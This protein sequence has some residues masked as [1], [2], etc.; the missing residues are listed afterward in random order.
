MNR[1]VSLFCSCVI[2]MPVLLPAQNGARPAA[3]KIADL[4]NDV[5][6]SVDHAMRSMDLAGFRDFDF[7][8]MDFPG[9]EGVQGPL[10][11]D[12]KLPHGTWWRDADLIKRIGLSSDQQKRIEDLFLQNKIQLI[13]LHASL[14]EE[15]LLLQP[16]LDGNPPDQ[17]KALTQI[18]KIADTRAD[19]EKANA[20]M[21][22]GI[23]GVLTG[24]QWTRLQAERAERR[25]RSMR[26]M[27]E[28]VKRLQGGKEPG[29]SRGRHAPP[30]PATPPQ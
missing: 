17:T 15:E 20:R 8:G 12:L 24:D 13:H 9:F 25:E 18:S 23:R 27:R 6:A 16:V 14:Q 19:L 29:I 4:S 3:P 10:F 11:A 21:L 1:I 22:L 28:M 2:A 5:Q 30:I 7:Q 26:D